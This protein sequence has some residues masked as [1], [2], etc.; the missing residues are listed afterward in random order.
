M[1]LDGSKLNN[2][3]AIN[4]WRYYEMSLASTSNFS[5]LLEPCT[6]NADLFASQDVYRPDRQ[7]FK[8]SASSDSAPDLL[9]VRED[10]KDASIYVGVWG[11]ME[12]TYI[13]HAS[14]S[15]SLTAN[16]PRPG[17]H[18][19][20]TLGTP[21]PRT[22]EIT[23]TPAQVATS[24]RVLTYTVYYAEALQNLVLYTVCGL[25]LATASTPLTVSSTNNGS[26]LT[27]QIEELVPGVNYQFN[28]MVED[29]QGYR[30]VYK[31]SPGIKPTDGDTTTSGGGLP[32]K[33]LIGVGVPVGIVILLGIVYLVIKNRKLTKELEIEMHDVP[34]A[35]VRKAV[36][37][38][39]DGESVTTTKGP[40]DKDNKKEAQK[41]HKLLTEDEDETEIAPASDL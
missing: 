30:S 34:K 36:G 22:V 16:N 12:S 20:L 32:M 11:V 18:G 5:V 9:E 3:V 24:S 8:W 39:L 14:S 31:F 26:M 13:I 41:Y 17:D 35:A 7:H 19:R 40:Q 15:G 38:S 28:V 1:L 6:G 37:G 4:E 10:L 23:W 27:H 2:S 29:D 33:Y 25:Q 21:R